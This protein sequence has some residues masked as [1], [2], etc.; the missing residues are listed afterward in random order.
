MYEIILYDSTLKFKTSG[1]K[2]V[3]IY[4]YFEHSISFNVWKNT[5]LMETI[6]I[7][8]VAKLSD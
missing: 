7:K 2:Y 8:L 5:N 1:E 3:C 4:I 6:K